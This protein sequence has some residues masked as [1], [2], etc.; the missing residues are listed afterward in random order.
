MTLFK[1]IHGTRDIGSKA[2]FR[3]LKR[4]LSE[5]ISRGWVERIAVLKPDRFRPNQEWYRD[6]KT[7]EIYF[8]VPPEDRGGYWDRVDPK[9]LI[10]P[11]DKIQ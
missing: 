1:E 8:L 9:N 10:R 2:E 5:A 3:E 6:T 11:D 7:G 4:K